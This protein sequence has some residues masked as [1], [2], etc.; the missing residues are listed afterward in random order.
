MVNFRGVNNILVFNGYFQLLTSLIAVY[1]A[2][3]STFNFLHLRKRDKK[4]VM[5]TLEL[6]RLE[7]KRH[8]KSGLPIKVVNNG[9]RPVAIA[10]IAVQESDGRDI[11]GPQ[12]D[13]V[14]R[15]FPVILTQSLETSVIIPNYNF[16]ASGEENYKFTPYAV[17][18]EGQ[19]FFGTTR[20]W[21]DIAP[22]VL[23]EFYTGTDNKSET[24]PDTDKDNK[25]EH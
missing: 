23:P 19:R 16:I 12:E 14:N 13:D 20:S 9:Y 17:D 7:D 5:V 3:L 21:D 18:N 24:K 22:L 4:S 1:G 2:V 15:K 11:P 10:K 25:S 6:K 8:H